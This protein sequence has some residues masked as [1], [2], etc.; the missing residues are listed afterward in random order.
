M[1]TQQFRIL[2]PQGSLIS[3]LVTIDR[4]KYIVR[5]LVQVEGCTL[6]TAL[7]AA[8]TVEQAEDNSRNR[9]LSALAL[10]SSPN[11]APAAVTEAEKQPKRKS[12]ETTNT[13]DRQKLKSETNKISS[14][15]PLTDFQPSRLESPKATPE[16]ERPTQNETLELEREFASKASQT[17]DREDRS[18]MPASNSTWQEQKPQENYL[19]NA[20]E[21]ETDYSDVIAKTDFELQRLRWTKQQGVEHLVQTYGKRSRLT[22]SDAEL[23]EFLH[24]LESLPTPDY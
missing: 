7:A 23:L 4:G 10:D 8:D 24:Y 17:V 16:T 21:M 14:E 9:A 20:N 13:N 3:E 12:I 5:T 2:Y 19:N 22:L 15:R 1:L 6:A 11:V 18:V